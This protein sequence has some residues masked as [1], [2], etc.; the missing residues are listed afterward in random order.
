LNTGQHL[1]V[2]DIPLIGLH[3]DCDQIRTTESGFELLVDLNVW[4]VFRKQVTENRLH[5]NPT[6]EDPHDCRQ[7]KNGKNHQLSVFYE[8]RERFFD[9]TE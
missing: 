8:K 3:H 6:G 9:F 5:L 4:V 7:Q 2:K 1:L